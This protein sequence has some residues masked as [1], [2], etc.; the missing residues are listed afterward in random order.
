MISKQQ[1]LE[2][3][4]KTR[5]LSS[6]MLEPLA[7]PFEVFLRMSQVDEET[8]DKAID[9][10]IKNLEKDTEETKENFEEVTETMKPKA[11]IQKARAWKLKE[12]KGK[13]WKLKENY[14]YYLMDREKPEDPMTAPQAVKAIKDYLDKKKLHY[15]KVS[16]EVVKDADLSPGEKVVVNVDALHEKMWF[17]DL[18]AIS[19]HYGFDIWLDGGIY[20]EEAEK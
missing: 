14:V 1:A 7:I 15:R 20:S 11:K 3:L 12:N 16:A 9:Y 19:L 5:L 17:A 6:N 18:K 8:H 2:E 4:K 10:I 13:A